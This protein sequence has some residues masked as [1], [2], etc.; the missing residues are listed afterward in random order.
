MATSAPSYSYRVELAPGAVEPRHVSS[1]GRTLTLASRDASIASLAP[2][3]AE[4]RRGELRVVL[5]VETDEGAAELELPLRVSRHDPEASTWWLRGTAYRL[6]LDIELR[7]DGGSIGWRLDPGGRDASARALVLDLLIAL[8]GT[9]VVVFRDPD[10][11]ALAMLRLSAQPVDPSIREERAFLTQVLLIEVWSGV[12]LPLPDQPD[13]EE[14]RSV[15]QFA[16]WIRLRRLRGRFTS[17]I[18]AVTADRV[19]RCDELVL[20]SIERFKV[21]GIDVP[22]GRVRFR[23]RVRVVESHRNDDGTWTTMFEAGPRLD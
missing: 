7:E 22:L 3:E 20:P 4:Q 23:V 1:A 15:A 16:E 9:G 2:F 18:T 12:R 14:L 6:S 13:D 19:E 10:F 21:F 11:G 8:S 5:D 17:T